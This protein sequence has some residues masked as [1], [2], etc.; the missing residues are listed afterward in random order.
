MKQEA[1]VGSGDRPT[2]LSTDAQ[3]RREA[4]VREAGTGKGTQRVIDFDSRGRCSGK[5]RWGWRVDPGGN[6]LVGRSGR[7]VDETLRVFAERGGE[8]DLARRV[9]GIG[10]AI[11]HLVRG[12]QADPGM[13]MV[14][15]IPVEEGAA[16]ASCVLDASEGLGKRG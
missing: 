7:L 13:A 12:H 2:A 1:S 9:D 6:W 8:R 4:A 15:V 5:A 11:M 14:A 16:E 3:R 10:L